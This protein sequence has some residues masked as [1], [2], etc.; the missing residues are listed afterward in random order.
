MKT[1]R[2]T[3]IISRKLVPFI[4][5]LTQYGKSFLLKKKKKKKINADAAVRSLG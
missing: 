3:S 5:E 2:M 1:K 4:L